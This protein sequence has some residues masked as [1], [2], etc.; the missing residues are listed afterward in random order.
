MSAVIGIAELPLDCR[1]IA[2]IN[3]VA[4]W[5]T[6]VGTWPVTATG[7]VRCLGVGDGASGAEVP[8]GNASGG[9]ACF[10]AAVVTA[11]TEAL[12][13]DDTTL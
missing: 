7:T 10:G 11:G 5:A 6:P 9:D 4:T 13:G 3:P 1:L 8:D 12:F 2:P